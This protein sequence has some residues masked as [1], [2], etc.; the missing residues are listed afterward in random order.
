MLDVQDLQAWY[1]HSHVIQGL[2]FQVGAGE[3]V[4]L[5][6]RNG[7]GKTTTLRAI[8][9]LVGKRAGNARFQGQEILAS[10][11]HARYHHGLAY[12]PED[13]RIVST[14]TVRENLQLGLLASAGRNDLATRVD[15]I[16]ETFPRLKERLDQEGTSL[17]GGEQQ[18]LAIAR[19]M[20]ARPKMIL[21]DEPS[22]GI[23]PLL[24]EEM[25]ALFLRMKEQGTT[26][27][28]VEQNVER[29]LSI[30]DRAYVIDQGRIVHS[31]RAAELLADEEIQQR[32][33]A[34]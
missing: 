30:S 24:V 26:L 33:C 15:E 6:G 16:A 12:V 10:P 4:T 1:D 19:A 22:E 28:L 13:R 7:A 18:M 29:A 5:L 3:I 9:G 31:G 17:S 25:F 11:A 32:Y 8:M 27:L 34:V 21:L 23:M 20:V 2:S 14:L